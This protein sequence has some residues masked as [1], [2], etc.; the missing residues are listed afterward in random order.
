MMQEATNLPVTSKHANDLPVS[1][2]HV[3]F[4]HEN[5][6]LYKTH[7]D[8]QEM[9]DSAILRYEESTMK[10]VSDGII[11]KNGHS[12]EDHPKPATKEALSLSTKL[13]KM[14]SIRL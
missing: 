12:S 13:W 2:E 5:N 14:L 6:R 1:G 7:S 10:G 4:L 11:R 9:P 3:E 8:I